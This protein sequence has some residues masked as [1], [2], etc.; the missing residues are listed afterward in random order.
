MRYRQLDKIIELIPGEKIVATRQLRSDEDYLRDHFPLFPVM[1]GVMMLE[2]LFQASC[3]L[4]RSSEDFSNSVLTLT[5]VR[6]VKFADFM[7]PGH[8]LTVVAEI[9]K[10]EGDSVTIKGSGSRGETVAVSGRL[11]ITKSSLGRDGDQL[12]SLDEYLRD[13]MRREFEKLVATSTH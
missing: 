5:E 6:N 9:I 12:S 8:T 11:I 4:I 10:S 2:A 1:P 13:S 7:E 3:W